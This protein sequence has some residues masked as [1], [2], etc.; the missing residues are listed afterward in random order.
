MKYSNGEMCRFSLDE[1]QLLLEAT[2]EPADEL[3]RACRR[4]RPVVVVVVVAVV[5]VVVVVAIAVVCS[6]VCITASNVL[7]TASSS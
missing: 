2:R 6:R 1:L 4:Y 5:I 3:S 7:V